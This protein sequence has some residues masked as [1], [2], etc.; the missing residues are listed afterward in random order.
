[1]IGKRYVGWF[2]AALVVLVT[3]GV[4][5]ARVA[6]NR[7][8]PPESVL[9]LTQRELWL[10][11]SSR[12]DESTGVF[13][14]L[15]VTEFLT[16][17]A[18]EQTWLDEA[19]L[20]TLGFDVHRVRERLR[21]GH[22][23]REPAREVYAALEFDGPAWREHLRRLEQELAEVTE[24]GAEGSGEESRAA[25]ARRN[26]ERA[27][28]DGSRLV[29]I[30]ADLDPRELR[31]RHPDRTQV[32]IT[33]ALASIY[34]A[35]PAGADAG[36]RGYLRAPLVSEIHV[37]KHLADRLRRD[38]PYTVQLQYGAAYEPWIAGIEVMSP[39]D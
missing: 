4:I 16:G 24:K 35:H 25:L 9:E 17:Q 14:H 11:S 12:S 19:K 3:N 13:L 21:K 33:H 8:G 7:S 34:P 29:A 38:T 26:L 39:R 10:R 20:A 31:A 6:S 2:G 22:P 36:I 28:T 27:R 37:P 5:L 18:L 23:W 1:M 15:R 32:A 30:D